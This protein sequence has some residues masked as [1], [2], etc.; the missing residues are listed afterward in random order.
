MNLNPNNS[1]ATIRT[2]TRNT[3]RTAPC[4][5]TAQYISTKR[6]HPPN[7][8]LSLYTTRQWLRET[9]KSS[10][11]TLNPPTSPT[12]RSTTPTFDDYLPS[13]AHGDVRLAP[14]S[15]APQPQLFSPLEM[16]PHRPRFAPPQQ[17][18]PSPPPLLAPPAP[19]RAKQESPPPTSFQPQEATRAD[20][21]SAEPFETHNA[22]ERKTKTPRLQNAKAA[23]IRHD[24]RVD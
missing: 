12:V 6:T 1:A 14:P 23:R 21:A 20:G 13:P 19:K 18:S 4:L 17:P 2:Q 9:N 24:L 5:S 10:T 22:T 7:Q 11:A 3:T 15:T 8:R 16:H